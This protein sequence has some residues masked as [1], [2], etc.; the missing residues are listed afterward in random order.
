V[1]W[2]PS[3]GDFPGQDKIRGIR[4]KV[5]S[6]LAIASGEKYPE[7]GWQTNPG[8]GMESN[9]RYRRRGADPPDM[10]GA[11]LRAP[12]MA[13]ALLSEVQSCTDFDVDLTCAIAVLEF[14][15]HIAIAM[16]PYVP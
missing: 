12:G 11:E 1:D 7:W 8:N 6:T 16:K 5:E 2:F 3:G 9:A 13:P 4:I 10:T 14:G 15:N